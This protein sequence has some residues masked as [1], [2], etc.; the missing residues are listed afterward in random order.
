MNFL[1]L[2]ALIGFCM[3]AAGY[4]IIRFW[5]LPI[6][7]Y[8]QI[9][10]KISVLFSRIETADLNEKGSRISSEHSEICRK[11]S[12]ALTD[13][14]YDDLP[15]WYRLVLA[16]HRKEFPVEASRDLL[17]LSNTQHPDHV[18]TRIDKI[19]QYLNLSG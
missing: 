16:H 2:A 12:I 5:V 9:K 3:G 6:G 13:I 11:H 19:R 8:H 1:F 4:I 14:F 18:R 7:R 10:K 15:E 17:T